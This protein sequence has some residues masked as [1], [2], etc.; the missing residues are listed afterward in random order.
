MTVPAILIPDEG[1]LGP[2]MRALNERQR[3]FVIAMLDLGC[4]SNHYRAAV[5]AGY[6]GNE[7]T[8]RVT[9]HRLAHDERVQAAI[10]EEARA[11]L[12]SGTIAAASFL[13]DV[14]SN[15]KAQDKDRLKA[16][17]M[18]MDRGG[19]HALSE[20][21]ITVEHTDDRAE[22]IKK[23]VEMCLA[24]GEDPKKVLGNTADVIEA[25]FKVIGSSSTA[26]DGTEGIED[27]LR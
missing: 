18:L 23:L 16:A 6:N 26:G 24:N 1:K 13:F 12:T 5:L 21:K 9:A 20:H 17:Q 19:L 14:I 4:Q 8:L 3:R 2:A 15:P 7:N 27:L 22:K 11:R 10:L 25:E